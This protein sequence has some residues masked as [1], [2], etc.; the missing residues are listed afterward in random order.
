MNWDAISAIGQVAGA[1][2]VLAPLVY[3][4]IQ[5]RH[6]NRQAEI[7]A[8]RHTW[9]MLNQFCDALS[10]SEEMASLVN[11]GRE[12]LSNL[13]QDELL[14]FEHLHIRLLNTLESW[15]LQ[16]DR[17]TRPG[18]YRSGQ[19]ENIA[20]IAEGYLGFPGTRDL[21]SELSHYFLPVKGLIDDALDGV[22]A[23]STS[24]TKDLEPS[25]QE[26]PTTPIT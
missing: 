6:T 24:R 13:N 22:P 21:W 26:P 25:P 10:R 3:L 12:S 11:R 15:H 7:E 4:S 9:D 16:I 19:F 20:G 2:A 1:V 17:T 14:M 18:P 5:V 23:L 8:H